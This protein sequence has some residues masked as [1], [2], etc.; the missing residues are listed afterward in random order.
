MTMCELTARSAARPRAASRARWLRELALL[1]VLYA[2]YS[3]ARL[4]DL[5]GDTLS[6]A[7]AHAYDLL[8]VEQ[9][10]HLDIEAPAN[11]TLQAWPLLAVAASYW[12]SVLHYVVTP[13]V[14][15]WAYRNRAGDYRRVRDALVLGSAIG[16]VGFTLL[17]MAPPRMLP[18]FVDTLASTSGA[19]WWGGD[20]SA[21]RG[22]GAL[23]NQLAAMP[24]LH[25]GWA[26]WV[27]WV[28]VTLST[29]RWVKVL[30]VAYP[31]GTTLVVVAT[32]N[33]Y[34]LDAIAGAL[35]VAVGI[36]LSR[37]LSPTGSGG[38]RPATA[39]APGRVRVPQQAMR[40]R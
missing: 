18:G 2:G 11:A 29:R 23:T 17:P 37:R 8:T 7:T 35:V 30:A 16:L 19:G 6:R 22:L 32:A 21:P 28:L 20:A 15:V 26:V 24:S 14:L 31:L 25:V 27:A 13:A 4:L 5:G 40:G 39:D 33:H 3:L 10:L 12:Y 34:L 38:R 36:R 9:A 1:A